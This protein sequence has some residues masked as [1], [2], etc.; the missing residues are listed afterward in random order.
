MSKHILV[1]VDGSRASMDAVR[2]LGFVIGKTA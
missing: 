2:Y 1:G